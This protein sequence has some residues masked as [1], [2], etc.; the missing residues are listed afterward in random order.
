LT[1]S[2]P[3]DQ[4]FP[5]LVSRTGHY[6][7]IHE[8]GFEN[9]INKNG[10]N[11]AVG[12]ARMHHVMWMVQGVRVTEARAALTGSALGSGEAIDPDSPRLKY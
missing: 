1:S 5:V 9:A 2:S 10:R 12:I 3:V 6:T 7:S 4:D 8:V 11:D